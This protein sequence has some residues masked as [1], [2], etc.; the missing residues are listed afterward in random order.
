MGTPMTTQMEPSQLP[1]TPFIFLGGSCN[2]TTWRAD[3]AMPLL[4]EQG[5]AFYNPQVDDWYPELMALE[6]RAKE[7]AAVNLFVID[8]DTRGL[9]SIMEAVEHIATKRAVAVAVLCDMH[10]GRKIG[11]DGNHRCGEQRPESCERV[12]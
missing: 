7:E 2:P 11:S 5:V 6:N 3:I 10:P 12:P 9:M 4:D 8:G 1:T